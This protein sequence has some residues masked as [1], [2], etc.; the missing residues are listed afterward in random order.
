VKTIL[1]IEKINF[2]K[3]ISESICAV[4]RQSVHPLVT[5]LVNATLPKQYQTNI[6]VNLQIRCKIIN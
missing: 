4:S 6:P 5:Y 3:D 2:L 1:N